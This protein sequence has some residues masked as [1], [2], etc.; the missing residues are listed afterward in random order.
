VNRDRHAAAPTKL[1][2][3]CSRNRIRSLTAEKLMEGVPGYDARSA[4]TQPSARI[5]V[6]AGANQKACITRFIRAIITAPSPL[7]PHDHDHLPAS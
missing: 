6:T 5:P 3:I 7:P 1:L 4:G 2:F